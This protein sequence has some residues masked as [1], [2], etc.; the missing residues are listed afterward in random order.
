MI[1]VHCAGSVSLLF[2]AA[3]AVNND[4]VAADLSSGGRARRHMANVLE[5]V[6]FC[7]IGSLTG[8]LVRLPK[9]QGN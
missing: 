4:K 9:K 8:L 3:R 5:D 6:Y 7:A 2:V 1:D